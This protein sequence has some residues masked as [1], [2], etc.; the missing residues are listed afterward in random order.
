MKTIENSPLRIEDVWQ[1]K[2]KMRHNERTSV[3]SEQNFFAMAVLL[4][5]LLG[6][7]I[8]WLTHSVNEET[9]AAN[10]KTL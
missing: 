9:R 6:S 4:P 8:Q 1:S 3:G 5:N 2:T 7:Y 10:E